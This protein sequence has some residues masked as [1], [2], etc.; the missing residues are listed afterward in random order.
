MYSRVLKNTPRERVQKKYIC[1][2]KKKTKTKQNKQRSIS[3]F[4]NDNTK[5]KKIKTSVLFS[6]TFSLLSTFFHVRY[7]NRCFL[8][9]CTRK[10]YI[11]ERQNFL[12][13]FALLCQ[14]PFLRSREKKI[15]DVALSWGGMTKRANSNHNSN[16]NNNR[17]LRRARQL[18][19]STQ[20]EREREREYFIK[21]GAYKTKLKKKVK[22]H[23]FQSLYIINSGED[24]RTYTAKEKRGK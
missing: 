16:N 3:N 18:A 11:Y 12:Y 14:T 7:S 20:G 4:D 8:N 21:E 5:K 15:A 24:T 13:F 23:T 1:Q 9:Q 17:Y 6:I 19:G 2:R 22:K 10:K